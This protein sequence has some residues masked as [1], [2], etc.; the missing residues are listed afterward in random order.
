M[1]TVHYSGLAGI[2]RRWFSYVR[3]MLVRILEHAQVSGTAV[4]CEH[5]DEIFI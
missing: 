4:K 1:D 2:S 5:V 3:S